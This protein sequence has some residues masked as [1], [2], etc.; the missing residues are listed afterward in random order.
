M[1]KQ[2][3]Q[4]FHTPGEILLNFSNDFIYY[5]AYIYVKN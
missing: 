2:N 4:N 5:N 3:F 1:E